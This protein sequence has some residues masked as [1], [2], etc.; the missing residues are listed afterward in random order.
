M[1]RLLTILLL[2]GATAHG[3]IN[4]PPTSVNIVDA[5]ATGRAV[6]TAANAAG[7]A[8]AI[9]LGTANEVT[10]NRVQVGGASFCVLDKKILV[11][12]GRRGLT[13][14]HFSDRT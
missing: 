14:S 5:T 9:G 8:T 13:D 7:A 4:N 10:F 3:Q 6:L 1:N 2:L 11:V 12:F